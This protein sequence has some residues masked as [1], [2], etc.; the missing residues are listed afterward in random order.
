MSNFH[1]LRHFRRA[2]DLQAAAGLMHPLGTRR[3]ADG[4]QLN[5]CHPQI[6]RDHCS[7]IRRKI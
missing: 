1:G 5:R 6:H 4:R 3:H 2:L 7:R